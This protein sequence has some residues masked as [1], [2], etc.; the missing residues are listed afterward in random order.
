MAPGVLL[1]IESTP[2]LP[3]P[4]RLVEGQLMVELLPSFHTPGADLTR[5]SEKFWVVPEESER[6]AMVIAVL[7][8]LAPEFRAL[9]AGSFQVLI[10][11]SKILAI[12]GP[13]SL[14]FFTPDRLYEIA[15]GPMTTGKY[16]MVAPLKPAFSAAGIG[17]SE[18]A[19]LTT[20]D[21]RAVRPLPEP[22]P[23]ELTVRL[24]S[25]DLMAWMAACW[26]VVWKVDPLAFS[27]PETAA[28]AL[29]LADALADALL[30]D[31]PEPLPDDEQAATSATAARLTPPAVAAFWMRT[32]CIMKE[33]LFVTLDSVTTANGHAS[34]TRGHTNWQ[35][36]AGRFPARP[37]IVLA[38]DVQ[39][40][41]QRVGP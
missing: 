11:P 17:E 2:P 1:T 15:I 21:A 5:N 16:R 26:K 18:T 6:R 32:R 39:Q 37:W 13:S 9:M 27:V 10:V 41:A 35:N 20:P 25:V 40:L 33:P 3:V 4:P 28:G 34:A 31:P 36:G 14:R 12:V 19:K 38:V 7:G 30:L 23:P 24:G 29:L 22:Q 8:R